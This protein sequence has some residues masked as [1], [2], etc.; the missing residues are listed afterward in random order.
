MNNH[1]RGAV[2]VASTV[3]VTVT[4]TRPGPSRA[5]VT[6]TGL[7]GQVAVIYTLTQL[8]RVWNPD[9][10]SYSRYIPCI[11]HVYDVRLRYIMP[12]RISKFYF[13]VSMRNSMLQ[14]HTNDIMMV[15]DNIMLKPE[16][17][18]KA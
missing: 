4:V 5:G 11:F 12:M 16:M 7:I 2:T 1:G 17:Y 3:T 15:E 9:E 10:V 6:A 13:H 8:I 18:K 14:W